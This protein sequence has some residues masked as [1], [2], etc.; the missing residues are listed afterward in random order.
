M[1]KQELLNR[2]HNIRHE[3]LGCDEQVE[4]VHRL[5][6]DLFRDLGEVQEIDLPG[7]V[8]SEPILIGG[9]SLVDTIVLGPYVNGNVPHGTL[10][11]G[12]RDT[13][14]LEM[15]RNGDIFVMGRLAGNDSEV[16]MALREWLGA[17]RGDGPEADQYTDEEHSEA[18]EDRLSYG[19]ERA[20]M[21]K[22]RAEHVKCIQQQHPNNKHLT[23]CGQRYY[24]QWVFRDID[25]AVLSAGG[26]LAICPDCAAI[27]RDKLASGVEKDG[28]SGTGMV[29][30]NGG[31]VIHRVTLSMTDGEEK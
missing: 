2:L 26:S 24:G 9:A 25:H 27:V 11:I 29:G 5:L 4:D 7:A 17:M 30:P 28:R 1:H 12:I 21:T 31:G 14:F 20:P 23:W 18:P 6:D 10:L 3:L 15:H 8:P 19:S 22:V 16:V 13:R